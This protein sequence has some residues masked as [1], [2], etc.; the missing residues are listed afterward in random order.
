M[1]K[2]NFEIE[3]SRFRDFQSLFYVIPSTTIEMSLR[4][5]L[6]RW[7]SEKGFA[8]VSLEDSG[9]Y[10]KASRELRFV[11]SI[12]SDGISYQAKLSEVTESGTWRSSFTFSI[13]K[14]IGKSGVGY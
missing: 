6:K 8:D 10:P 5:Q 9:Y 2:G 11:H 7:L 13:P 3:A 12:S 4:F 14:K 1:D